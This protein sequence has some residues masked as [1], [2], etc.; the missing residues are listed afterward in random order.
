MGEMISIP[1]EEYRQLLDAAADLV[2]LAAYDAAKRRIAAGDDELI[3]DEIVTRLLAGE[4]PVKVWREHRGL[5]QVALAAASG[6]N[7]VQIAD[8]EA[9]RKSGS[10]ETVRKLAGALGL[11]IDEL[12]S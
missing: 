12:L 6:V 4:A 9:G 10:I 3:P 7:R 11:T 8:I 1:I 5:S 2:D